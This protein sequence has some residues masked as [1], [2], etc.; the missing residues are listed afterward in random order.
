MKP[1]LSIFDTIL[2]IFIGMLIGG[3]FGAMGNPLGVIAM[4]PITTALIA[5][6]PIYQKMKWFT[7]EV[8]PYI[9]EEAQPAAT[10]PVEKHYKMTA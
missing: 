9:T 8:N 1:N 5:W 6:D 4:Y 2:R 10:A 3:I 7:T